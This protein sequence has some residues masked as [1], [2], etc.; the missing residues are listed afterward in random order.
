MLEKKFLKTL[1]KLDRYLLTPLPHELDQN[2]DAN[3]SSRQYLDGNSLTLADCNLLPKLNIVGVS[4]THQGGTGCTYFTHITHITEPT[5]GIFSFN[6]K[7][8]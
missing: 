3:E 7:D 8:I 6:I 5:G 1:I 4:R 2:P